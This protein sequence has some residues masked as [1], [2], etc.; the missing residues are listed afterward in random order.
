MKK[1]EMFQDHI[2]KLSGK[3]V[4][5]IACLGQGLVMKFVLFA[6][7]FFRITKTDFYKLDGCADSL[8]YVGAGL[9][10]AGLAEI[11]LK[12]KNEPDIKN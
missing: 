3:R 7:S 11:F 8:I 1:S 5:G 12:G 10:G 2:G 9:L 6:Y 4:G